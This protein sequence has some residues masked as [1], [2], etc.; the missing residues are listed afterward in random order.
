MDWS[1]RV[2]V[3]TRSYAGPHTEHSR[4]ADVHCNRRKTIL[5]R[6][7][8]CICNLDEEQLLFERLT[9]VRVRCV[10]VLTFF[11]HELPRHR[12]SNVAILLL[13]VKNRNYNLSN[14]TKMAQPND[15]TYYNRNNAIAFEFHFYQ[16][17]KLNKFRPP[18]LISLN[19]SPLRSLIIINPNININSLHNYT[20]E[21]SSFIFS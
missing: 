20:P 10:G 11:L 12:V 7:A 3:I 8:L 16:S 4:T 6:K 17:S 2:G 18:F 9:Y 5:A 13:H 14:D 15:S 21:P 1:T 19:Q